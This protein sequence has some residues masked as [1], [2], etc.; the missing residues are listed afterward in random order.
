MGSSSSTGGSG[1]AAGKAEVAGLSMAA[2]GGL[3]FVLLLTAELRLG[4]GPAGFD[5]SMTFRTG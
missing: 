4:S 5:P 3:L 2:E 1:V